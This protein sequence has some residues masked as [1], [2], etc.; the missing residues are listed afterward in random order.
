MLQASSKVKGITIEIGA[1]TT[2]FGYA[3]KQIKQEASLVAKD[4]R[5]VDEAMKLDPNNVEKAADKLKLLREAADNATKKVDTI[6]KAIEQLNKEYADKSSA[7]YTK[8]LDFLTRSL[9]SASREQE[10]ANARLKDF[11]NNA[12]EAQVSAESF[13]SFLEANLTSSVILGGLRAIADL[14]KSI[15]S[16]LLNAAKALAEFS[17]EAV[18]S[19]AEYQDAIGYSET[20]FG[21]ASDASLQWAKDNSLALRIS[22][23]ELT[24]YM[25]TLGQ[26][27]HTQGIDENTSLTMVENLMSLAADIRAATG[28]S[29]DEILPIM[30]RGFTT[31]VKNFRQFGVVMTEA[32]VKAYALANGMGTATENEEELAIATAELEKAQAD[33][34]VAMA[35]HTE[36]SDEFAKAEEALTAAEE[37]YNEAFE[38]ANVTL[39]NADIITARYLLLLENLENIIGQNEHESEL[40]NSQLALTKTQFT[41]LKDEIGMKLL[42]VFTDLITKFNEFLQ[43]DAGQA[44]LKRIVD[45]FEQWAATISEMMDDGR[46]TTFLNDLI[47]ELPTIAGYIGDLV[48]KLLELIPKVADIADQFIAAKNQS[49]GFRSKLSEILDLFKLD[50]WD[51]IKYIIN[52]TGILSG[53]TSLFTKG[54][55][56][57][58]SNLFDSNA[59]GGPVSAGQLLRV[60]DD[61]G[62]R[63]EMFVPSVPGTILNGNQVDKIINNN[64]NSRTVGDVNIYMTST[65]ANA[66]AIADQIGFEVQK[67]LRMSGANLY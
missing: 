65:G 58:L 52:P 7:E 22:R 31:S 9:E 5:S 61:A 44:I 1:D 38:K 16:E 56:G 67:R 42:P 54:I 51:L 40:F 27:L 60:N 57:G 32:Q 35:L 55:F 2:S 10:I 29:T 6:K 46:L 33:A 39:T 26:L 63:T 66:S 53:G 28:K 23:K 64:N 49:E 20:V 25:N 15:A 13:A 11:E 48:T 47:D 12:R 18:S 45:Q 24:Q 4:M 14:A 21:D 30:Q 37:K 8:Q 19:A 41:N 34:A 62:H 50:G 3:M 43:S 36:E 59:Q 17:K